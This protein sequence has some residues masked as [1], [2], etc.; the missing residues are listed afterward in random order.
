MFANVKRYNTL[1]YWERHRYV[2]IATEEGVLRYEIFSGYE[3]KTE[4]TTYGLSF[5]QTETKIKFLTYALEKSTANME[6]VPELTDRI[7][8]L[9]T[10]TNFRNGRRWVVQAVCV[11][12]MSN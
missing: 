7:L 10:C 8:T 1:W 2:Y 11:D 4:S 5:Q 12:E 9:S 6:I 3:T